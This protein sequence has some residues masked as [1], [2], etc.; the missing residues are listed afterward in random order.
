MKPAKPCWC[1]AQGLKD[2]Q[3]ATSTVVDPLSSMEQVVKAMTKE[4]P[5]P[6][7]LKEMDVLDVEAQMRQVPQK[8]GPS[9]EHDL[10]E[11][12]IPVL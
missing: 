4:K 7:G 6:E 9:Q 10:V 12:V 1:I 5:E 11:V 2:S 3:V 8:K